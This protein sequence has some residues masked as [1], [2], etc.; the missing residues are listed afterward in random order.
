MKPTEAS[1]RATPTEINPWQDF[2]DSVLVPVLMGLL[3]TP[4][5]RKM[6]KS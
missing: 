4:I 6:H 5:S 2:K 3:I 1:D